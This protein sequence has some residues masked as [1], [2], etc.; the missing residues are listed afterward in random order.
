MLVQLILPSG[1]RLFFW[2]YKDLR[3]SLLV[4]TM[5]G[6]NESLLKAIIKI[7]NLQLAYGTRVWEIMLVPSEV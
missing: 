3:R 7:I 4:D 2:L 6:G 1:T 5:Y